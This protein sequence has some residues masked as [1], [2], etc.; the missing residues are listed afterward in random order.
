MLWF[1]GAGVC[2]AAGAAG[3][4]DFEAETGTSLRGC[5]WGFKRCRLCCVVGSRV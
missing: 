5:F 3:G 4:D 1:C 2:G